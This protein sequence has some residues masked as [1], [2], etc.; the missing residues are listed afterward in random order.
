MNWKKALKIG[1][2]LVCV[3]VALLL[4][5]AAYDLFGGSKP[6]KVVSPEVI[7]LQ[8]QCESLA[9][10]NTDLQKLV[11]ETS[12]AAKQAAD[13]A[14]KAITMASKAP[15]VQTA[16]SAPRQKVQMVQTPAQQV[17]PAVQQ[18]LGQVGGNNDMI[19]EMRTGRPAIIHEL[20]ESMENGTRARN[21]S[22]MSRTYTQ[23]DLERAKEK[24]FQLNDVV[25]DLRNKIRSSEHS[26]VGIKKDTDGERSLSMRSW[27]RKKILQTQDKVAELQEKLSQGLSDLQA[28]SDD[29]AQINRALAHH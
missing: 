8:K 7:A 10:Q 20:N 1:G 27:G 19:L 23:F 26:L 29:V 6:A 14:N 5:W 25:N 21:G 12:V 22:A 18:V 16:Q 9:K 28:A 17:N 11:A 13:T 4:I 15:V 2:S 24:E 3:I